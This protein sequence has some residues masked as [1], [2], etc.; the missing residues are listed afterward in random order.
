MQMAPP[1][2]CAN[3]WS[4]C[5][6]TS[7]AS[8]ARIARADESRCQGGHAA[9]TSVKI[10]LSVL[11]G[12]SVDS[13]AHAFRRQVELVT[14]RLLNRRAVPPGGAARSDPCACGHEASAAPGQATAV[15][16]SVTGCSRWSQAHWRWLE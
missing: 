15:V 4:A 13:C 6:A 3:T 2:R 8:Y 5:I 14:R 12:T 9:R 10:R 11:P 7:Y 1:R 16:V